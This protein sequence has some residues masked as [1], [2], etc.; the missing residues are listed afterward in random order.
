M[1]AQCNLL[2]IHR[3]MLYYKHRSEEEDVW[4]VNLIRD[5]WLKHTFYGYRKITVIL[6]VDYK[7]WV[8]GKRVLGLMRV[9]GIQAVYPKPRLS[10][11]NHNHKIYPYLLRELRVIRINQVWM[12][13]I[14]YLKIGTR[15]VYLVALIDVYSRYIVGWNLSFALDT[16]N[17]LDALNKAIKLGV[18]DII[19]SD[20]GCQFTSDGWIIS[21]AANGI[22]VS[23]DGK[24]RCK[25]NIYIERFWRTIKYEAIY[26]NEYANFTE[27]Y[28]GVKEYIDFYNEQRPHQSL[29]YLRPREIYQN[30]LVPFGRH[31]DLDDNNRAA[32]PSSVLRIPSGLADA[33][34]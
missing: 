27:L 26:L 6:R 22:R 9:A 29:G 5:I 3:S 14:T 4:L 31:T 11:N 34:T 25:D 15:Y 13:D 2:G 20:Q 28:N 1:R 10:Q 30:G 7:L 8:N 16:E 24:G 21:V 18:P 32:L 33:R 12:T 19:N 17:C 23:M